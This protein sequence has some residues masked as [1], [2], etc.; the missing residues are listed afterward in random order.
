MI[1]TIVDY[2]FRLRA[3]LHMQFMVF[4]QTKFI[5][6]FTTNDACHD[7]LSYGVQRPA[8]IVTQIKVSKPRC[9]TPAYKRSIHL[10]R[11]YRYLHDIMRLAQRL[12]VFA[13]FDSKWHSKTR[14]YSMIFR[15]WKFNQDICRVSSYVV[16]N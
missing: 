1:A 5:D 8:C 15:R 2:S 4:N 7:S 3:T 13:Y 14:Q 10:A 9:I 6:R 11:L 16:L 12:G